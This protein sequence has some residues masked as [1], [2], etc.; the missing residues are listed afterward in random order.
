MDSGYRRL[1]YIR[2]ADD[3]LIGIIG[4]KQDALKVMQDVT[5]FLQNT[6]KL[7]IAAEK[8][9]V[10]F[11]SDGV[12]FLGYEVRTYTGNRFVKTIRSGRHITMRSVTERMQLHIPEEKLHQFC[13]EKGYGAYGTFKPKH[14]S[15]LL[16]LSEAE[17]VQTYNAEMRGIANY[18]SL[19]TN[20]KRDLNKLYGLWHGSLLK[21]LAGKRQSTVRKVARSLCH[22]L[23]EALIVNHKGKVYRFPIYNL[24]MMRESLSTFQNIDR[25]P[26]TWQWTLSHTELIHR[27]AANQCEYCGEKAEPFEVHHIRKMADVK[28]GKQLWQTMMMRRQRK[29]LVMCQPCHK[30]LHAGTLESKTQST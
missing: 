11:A 12:R 27:M 13:D 3:T 4:S 19:A 16:Q 10:V 25:T 29:T 8:S 15:N 7:E 21:T 9:G 24:S 6:L 1:V 17:I 28:E 22:A 23:G 2:Y 30:K 18:Y 14:R 20:A 26:N 5:E